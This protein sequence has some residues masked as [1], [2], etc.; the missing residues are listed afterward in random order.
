LSDSVSVVI[1]TWNRAAGVVEAIA[2]ALAQ[3]APVLEV[4][5]CDDGSTDDTQARV[6]ALAARDPRVVWLPGARAGLPS[7]PR[8][9]GIRASRGEW[10]AF[11][12][13]D[14]AWRPEKLAV[15]LQAARRLDCAAVCANA[16]RVAADGRA[17]GALLEWSGEVLALADLLRDNL[18]I[19]SSLVARAALVKGAGGF[20]ESADLKVGEDYALWLRLAAQ[21]GIAY[22]PAELVRYRDDPSTSIR[23]QQSMTP[24]AMKKAVIA[25]FQ[26]WLT[27]DPLRALRLSPALWRVLRL[28]LQLGAETLRRAR[29]Q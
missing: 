11:L 21:T 6:A 1:P 26:A 17:L 9:R 13:S 5:V 7:V 24:F 16:Q 25:D 28:R 15:Q 18:V 14:D 2:S 19:C 29:A 10:L 12:D 8:N 4:L 3:S 27:A 23:G 22:C 20:P